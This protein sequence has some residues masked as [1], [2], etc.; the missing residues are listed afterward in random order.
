[1]SNL[2]LEK[3]STDVEILNQKDIPLSSILPYDPAVKKGRRLKDGLEEYLF[4]LNAAEQALEAIKTG[5]LKNFDPLVGEN[6]CQIR[7]VKLA[8]IISKYPLSTDHLLHTIQTAKNQ[9]E[10]LLNSIRNFKIYPKSLKE[11]L[12][13][14]LEVKIDDSSLYLIKAFLLTKVKV[15]EAINT[16]CPLTKLEYTDSK[17]IKEIAP[18]GTRFAEDFI[19]NLRKKLAEHSVSFIKELSK[20]SP[21][22]SPCSENLFEKFLIEHRGLKCLPGYWATK[23]LLDQALSDHIP[24]VMVAEQKA[25]DRDYKTIQKTAI[26][27]EATPDGY[28]ETKQSSLSS[29]Q[30]ALIFV[31]TSN[32]NFDQFPVDKE[33]W[34]NELLE[35][36]PQELFLAYAAMHRQYPDESMDHLVNSMQDKGYEHYKSKAL[37]WGCCKQN[38]SLYF[39][40]HVYCDKVGNVDIS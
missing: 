6:A 20:I 19:K 8:L 7:A 37:E 1:M 30:P 10:H 22:T 13:D 24:I 34:R 17:R 36:C 14:G 23:T 28:K 35:Y 27:Y 4:V 32:R 11:L 31:G 3:E 21:I 16:E 25:Q 40:T 39:F 38:P 15:E 2:T 18:V 26:Y 9:T 29:N 5:K 12:K 33:S